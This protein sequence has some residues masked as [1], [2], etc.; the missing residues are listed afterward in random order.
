M[1]IAPVNK[2]KNAITPNSFKKS[3]YATW[4]DDVATW[5]D[6]ILAWG[7]PFATMVNLSKNSITPVNKAKS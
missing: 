7:S 1:P 4:G 6:A 5:G 2:A 3:G